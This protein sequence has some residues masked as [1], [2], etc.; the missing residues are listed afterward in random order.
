[1]LREASTASGRIW[2]CDATQRVVFEQLTP[3][4]PVYHVAERRGGATIVCGVTPTLTVAQQ[5]A[6]G[7]RVAPEALLYSAHDLAGCVEQRRTRAGLR[8]G[9]YHA[10]QAG[11]DPEAG[12]WCLVCEDHG[13]C[14]NTD[15]LSHARSWLS[16]PEDWCPTC[17]GEPPV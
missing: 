13:G 3:D 7:K 9:L 2:V 14:V 12:V 4:G 11:L 17:Q 10:A 15:K 5:L 1:M 8:V 6:L 16:H